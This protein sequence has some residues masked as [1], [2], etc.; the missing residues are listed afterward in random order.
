M[1]HESGYREVIHGSDIPS[2]DRESFWRGIT[3][4]IPSY[5]HVHSHLWCISAPLIHFHTVEWYHGNRVFR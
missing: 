3:A 5:A 4:V 2:D 1:K